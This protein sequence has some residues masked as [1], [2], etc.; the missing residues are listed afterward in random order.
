MRVVA[1]QTPFLFDG[2]VD[3][4][5]FGRFIVALVTESAALFHQDQLIGFTVVIMARFTVRLFEG[6]VN[7]FLSCDFLRPLCQV[8][9]HSV[10]TL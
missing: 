2:R 7:C 1:T 5:A 4:R 10:K 3:A 9:K 8:S 6:R